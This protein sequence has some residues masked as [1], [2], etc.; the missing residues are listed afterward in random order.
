[1]DEM[2][3]KDGGGAAALG[4]GIGHRLKIAWWHWTAGA[5]EEHATMALA[6]MLVSMSSKPRAY[7][8]SAGVSVGENGKRG[9]VRW[10]GR[11]LTSM[12]RR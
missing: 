10:E 8:Y 9:R 6:L 2:L 12:A 11:M 7:F 3:L 1:M 4:A 5:A